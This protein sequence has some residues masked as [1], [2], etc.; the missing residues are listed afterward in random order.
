[1]RFLFHFQVRNDINIQPWKTSDY[2]V[3]TNNS[4]VP[5]YVY[6]YLGSLANLPFPGTISLRSSRNIIIGSNEGIFGI[7]IANYQWIGLLLYQKTVGRRT[8]SA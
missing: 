1:M 3:L 7:R 6:M 4:S 2:Y 8:N 5:T